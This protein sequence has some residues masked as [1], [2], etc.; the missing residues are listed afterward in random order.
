MVVVREYRATMEEKYYVIPPQG[1]RNITSSIEAQNNRSVTHHSVLTIGDDVTLIA[2]TM[3]EI[4][5]G[6]QKGHVIY[7]KTMVESLIGSQ[8]SHM[9]FAP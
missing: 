3:V 9:T 1:L 7:P 6:L 2:K 8:N 4:V 5:I